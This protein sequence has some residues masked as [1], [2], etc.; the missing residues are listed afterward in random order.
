MSLDLD[1]ALANCSREPI[2][3]PG[4]IQPF[5]VLLALDP[6][7]ERIEYCSANVPAAFG[8]EPPRVL[9]MRP[10]DLLGTDAFDDLPATDFDLA[11]P[12][13][14]ALEREGQGRTWDVFVRAA[15]ETLARLA[16]ALLG[17]MGELETR[18]ARERAAQ[19]HRAL[20]E[21]MKSQSD[22]V[23]GLA[24]GSPT[25]LD[26]VDCT[27]V[28]VPTHDGAW[29]RLGAVPSNEQLSALAQWLSDREK[30]DVFETH[31]LSAEYPAAQ[32]FK[33]CG[34]GVLAIRIPKG[35]LNYVMWFR[36]EV[37][38]TV[39]WAGK[40]DKAVKHDAGAMRLVP[41]ASLTNGSRSFI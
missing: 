1:A 39:S 30:P 3:L 23:E 18:A 31:H 37:L 4:A 17:R 32:S 26:L 14:M 24:A 34:A 25:A 29:L 35:Q 38:Q 13:R 10:S 20:E 40:P 7:D 27:G 15:C 19:V 6:A 11:E 28:A 8:V 36:P 5:G 9:G 16:S 33:D 12:I 21:S 22:F 41:R 2:H